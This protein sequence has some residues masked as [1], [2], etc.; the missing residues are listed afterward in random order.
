MN[1]WAV[2][3]LSG[4][5]LNAGE[6]RHMRRSVLSHAGYSAHQVRFTMRKRKKE[7]RE[8]KKKEGRIVSLYTIFP[9]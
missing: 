3:P 4:A 5:C 1:P 8:G 9:R 6:V 7:K 2:V